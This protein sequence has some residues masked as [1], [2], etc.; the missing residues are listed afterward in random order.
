MLKNYLV[1]RKG[2]CIKCGQFVQE[3]IGFEIEAETKE[4]AIRKAQARWSFESF[5]SAGALR[6]ND[7]AEEESFLNAE[8]IA[9]EEKDEKEIQG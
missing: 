4:D 1:S 3:Q 2:K 7:I 8:F 6:E 5:G 9:Q